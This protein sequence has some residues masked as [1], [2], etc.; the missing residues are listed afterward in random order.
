VDFSI[1]ALIWAMRPW[2]STCLPF[3]PTIVVLSLSIT[4]RFAWPRS[5]IVAFSSFRPIS[6]EITCGAR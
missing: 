3:P 5:L 1:A 4:I 6:S 2:I